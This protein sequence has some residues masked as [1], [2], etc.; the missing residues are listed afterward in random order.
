MKINQQLK[1]IEIKEFEIDKEIVFNYPN[2]LK[3]E[4][5]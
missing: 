1:R 2:F 3:H 5:R 4:K